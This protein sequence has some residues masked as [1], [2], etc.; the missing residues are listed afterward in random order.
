MPE[1]DKQHPLGN[2][3]LVQ[4]E[5][6][7]E[8]MIEIFLVLRN[9]LLLLVVIVQLLQLDIVC[10]VYVLEGPSHPRKTFA[11]HACNIPINQPPSSSPS[12]LLDLVLL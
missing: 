11:V 1:L 5:V 6:P 9:L 7:L 2:R 3:F 12:Y 8:Q 10:S 4:V